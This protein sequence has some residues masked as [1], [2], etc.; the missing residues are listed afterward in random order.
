MTN[1]LY[2]V[3]NGFDLY[4][5]I[6]SRYADF[7]AFLKRTDPT[8]YEFV[9]R[10][11]VVDDSFWSEFEARLAD[12]DSDTLIE[13]ASE[14]LM[15]YGAEDWSDS[16][17]HDFQYE[18]Q[19]AVQAISVTMRSRFGDWVRQLAIPETSQVGPALLQLDKAARFLNFNYTRSLQTIYRV[20]DRQVLHIHGSAIVPD[21]ALV[22]GH[23]RNP[24]N[25]D[26]YRFETDPEAADIRVVEGIELID[27]YFKDTFKP[28]DEI[29]KEK[30]AFFASLTDVDL[31]VVLGHSLS[32]VDLPYFEE[33][34][35]HALPSTRW[36]VSYYGR[37]EY[38]RDTMS[39]L[40]VHAH[41][42]EFFTL[43]DI[44]VGGAR[45]LI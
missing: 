41:N 30:A 7:G 31:I 21:E 14:F 12:L 8:T 28:T 38:L 22:L 25:P 13:H 3:G 10:Y 1:R 9:D 29:L 37:N 23:G 45:G 4:H 39:G 36:A 32:E 18:I 17:H 2:V 44:A 5:G 19:R 20:P 26:P 27:T 35:S 24:G 34:I 15:S 16:G 6:A 33:I 43:P 42:V 11:F 40:G